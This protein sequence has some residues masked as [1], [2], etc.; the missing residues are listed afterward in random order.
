MYRIGIPYTGIGLYDIKKIA[1]ITGHSAASY[2]MK[3]DQFKGISGPRK[4]I[5]VEDAISNTGPGLNE[6]A[7]EDAQVWNDYKDTT[8]EDLIFLAKRILNEKFAAFK[9]AK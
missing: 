2:T 4:R 8:N 9:G 6:W 3:I 5:Y 7:K 1:E